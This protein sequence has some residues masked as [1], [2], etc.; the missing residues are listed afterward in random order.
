MYGC[1]A[2]MDV[3]AMCMQCPE[4]PEEG[5]SSSGTEVLDGCE[6]P[7]LWKLSPSPLKSSLALNLRTAPAPAFSLLIKITKQ[8]S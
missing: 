6:L 7:A 1:F 2:Y 5:I 3:C 8:I 4:G